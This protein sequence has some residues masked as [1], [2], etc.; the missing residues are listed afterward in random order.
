LEC[1]NCDGTGDCPVCGGSGQIPEGTPGF[2][3]I[4]LLLA[5]SMIVGFLIFNK[6]RR[7]KV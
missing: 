4:Y 3:G 7:K 5:L 2:E 6:K 1:D